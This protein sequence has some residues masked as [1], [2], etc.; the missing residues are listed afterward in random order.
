ML[1]DNGGF[2]TL[3]LR[4]KRLVVVLT[5]IVKQDKCDERERKAKGMAIKPSPSQALG[6]HKPIILC[7][8]SGDQFTISTHIRA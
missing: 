2:A 6:K 1:R 8:V 7:K 5:Q 4:E 3:T